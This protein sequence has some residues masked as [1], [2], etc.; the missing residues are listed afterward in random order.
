MGWLTG[1]V[2]YILI[3]WVC[4]FAVLPLWVTPSEPGDLGYAAGAPQ[5]PLLWRKL[6]LTTGLAAV[7]W[8]GVFVLVREPWISFRG[9]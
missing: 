5:R 7:I 8:L 1:I 9:E 2:V 3:W 4:L 6:A